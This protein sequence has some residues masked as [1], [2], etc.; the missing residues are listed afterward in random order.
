MSALRLRLDAL[1]RSATYRSDVVVA[2]SMLLAIV[3]MLIPLPTALV[4][5]LIAVNISFSLLVLIVA[6]CMGRPAGFSSLPPIILLATLFRLSL[7]IS[8][9]RL[10]LLDGDAGQIVETFGRF[11]IGGQVVVGLVIFLIITT[12]Q[13][14]V[15]TKGAERVAEVAARFT[16]DAMPGKQMSIDT[17]LRNGDI[18]QTEARARRGRLERE[19]QL[20]GAMDGAMKFVKGDAITGLIIVCINLIGG[21][22]T[23]MLQKGMS[24][25][26]AATTYSLL[27]VGDGL[28]AQ[29]P[30]LLISV[31]SGTVVTRVTSDR[32]E[33]LGS[34]IFQQLGA[35]E[36][37]LGL[38]AAAVTAGA[39]VPGFPTMVFLI[40]GAC[41]GGA[42]WMVRAR[43]LRAE[44]ALDES[45][46]VP[47]TEALADE[48]GDALPAPVPMTSDGPTR[49]RLVM[50]VGLGLAAQV[51]GTRFVAE[52]DRR[53]DDLLADQG[54]EMPAVEWHPDAS[55]PP[56]RMRID[57]EGVPVTVGEIPEG[58]LL[59][60]DDAAH[61]DLAGI[62]WREGP[63]AGLPG[64]SRWVAAADGA[65]LQ[66]AGIAT[67]AP[68]EVMSRCLERV[69]RGYAA[70]FIGL[71]E[72]R[73]MLSAIEGDHGE[74]VREASRLANIKRLAQLLRG[75]VEENV[76]IGNLR[77]ILEAV[78]EWAPAESDAAQLGERVRAALGRQ[79]CHRHAQL[80]RVL[81][82]CVLTRAVEQAIRDSLRQGAVT[83]SGE[84]AEALQRDLREIVE[85]QPQPGM[86]VLVSSDLRR[87]LRQYLMRAGIEVPVLSYAEIA[88]EYAVQ[89]VAS[90]ALPAPEGLAL[91]A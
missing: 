86:V 75:L 27:T 30:A 63:S 10:I 14:L 37:P 87:P 6:I 88:P 84:K 39:L 79:I 48:A 28:I 31:A 19:S 20:Y 91:T 51:P 32:D 77:L 56:Q 15:I 74:L 67:L 80:D 17:D 46:P 41:F 7:S 69:L 8:T 11:V 55:L 73:E 21:L 3:M 53:R 72:T 47:E 89:S 43:R 76:P 40:L 42:A 4:D 9:T 22:M 90:L 24:F 50:R 62:A 49:V 26:D 29:I 16:L 65:A 44:T 18:D 5:T 33:G 60:D 61:L 64:P 83:L 45:A 70:H 71:Q 38:A 34:E 59:L 13:F 23:G 1:A 78:V 36:R 68:V 35:S 81:S 57:L 66:A 82:A 52:A 25:G 58:C 85:G 12:A 54:L 2:A